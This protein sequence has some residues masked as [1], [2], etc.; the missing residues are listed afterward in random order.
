MEKSKHQKFEIVTIKRELIKNA[1]Y[2]PR[3]I[4]EENYKN[5][6]RNI[7]NRG[8][9]APL[10]WNKTTGNLIAGHQRLKILDQLE[11]SKNYLLSVACVEL[12]EKQEKE[13]NIFMNNLSAQGLFDFEK[14]KLMLP[15]IDIHAAGLLESD[16][17]ILGVEMDLDSQQGTEDELDNIINEFEAEKKAAKELKK[18]KPEPPPS[19]PNNPTKNSVSE[20]QQYIKGYN[21]ADHEKK[22]MDTYVTLTFSNQK[23]KRKFMSLAG[24][25][26]DD[27][28]IKGEIFVK[29]FF[30]D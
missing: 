3:F 24:Y 9:I 26:E 28:Y 20:A 17:N 4:E 16:L 14:V 12:D 21:K 18:Q 27:L 22:E 19:D 29:K 8:L 7:K 2:N 6:K 5:L 10:V 23:D 25:P 30:S 15:E 11:K 13:Q 1:P